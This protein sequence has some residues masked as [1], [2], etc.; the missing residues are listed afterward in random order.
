MDTLPHCPGVHCVYIAT[1]SVWKGLIK[2][3]WIKLINKLSLTTGCQSSY[4]WEK[5]DT[6]ICGDI[7]SSKLQVIVWKLQKMIFIK[8]IHDV[9]IL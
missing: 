3:N 2:L 6:K 5:V 7:S 9:I 8:N 4:P 1:P